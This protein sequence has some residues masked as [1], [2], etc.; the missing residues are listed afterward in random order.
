MPFRDSENL[1]D[2][3]DGPF[4]DRSPLRHRQKRFAD[5]SAQAH[6]RTEKLLRYR[7]RGLLPFQE[8]AFSIGRDHSRG[9]E[10]GK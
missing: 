5:G 3:I 4:A 9:R 7:S 8:S 2:A 1:V 6:G 10:K